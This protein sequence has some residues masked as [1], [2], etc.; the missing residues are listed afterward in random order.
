MSVRYGN[1][2]ESSIGAVRM[3]ETMDLPVSFLCFVRDSSST[4]PQRREKMVP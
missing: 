2:L 4:P 3:A 1:Y